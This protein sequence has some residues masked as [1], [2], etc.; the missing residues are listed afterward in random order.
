MD[1]LATPFFNHMRRPEEL[2]AIA[3]AFAQDKSGMIWIGTQSGL[4]R[5]DGYRPRLFIHDPQD[6]GSL[7]AN[8]ITGLLVDEQGILFV[9]TVSGIVPVMIR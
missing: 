1:G 5:W 4:V 3:M 2:P 6:A 9:A 7:P 8:V